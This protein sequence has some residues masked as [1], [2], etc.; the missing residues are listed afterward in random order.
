[1]LTKVSISRIVLL[2]IVQEILKQV[3][4]DVDLSWHVDY[5]IQVLRF[6]YY[7]QNLDYLI[8][9]LARRLY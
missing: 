8:K 6:S 5:Q 3:Q 7:S 1:M 9:T 4:D 2:L